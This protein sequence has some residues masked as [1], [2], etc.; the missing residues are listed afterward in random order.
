V[1]FGGSIYDAQAIDHW[2]RFAKNR[3]PWTLLQL[4]TPVQCDRWSDLMPIVTGQLWLA[5]QLVAQ[6]P[7]LQAEIL[8]QTYPWTG[9][10]IVWEHFS[11]V[12][13]TCSTSQTSR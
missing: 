6:R 8:G 3:R 7:L 5:R 2:Y 12:R 11:G 10:S 13:Y 9:G 1:K 4:S